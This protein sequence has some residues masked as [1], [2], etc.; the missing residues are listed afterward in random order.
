MRGGLPSSTA[1]GRSIGLSPS[2]LVLD[3]QAAVVGGA[4]RRR[5]TGSARAPH[6]AANVV[7]PVGRDRQHVALLRLV[8][9]QLERRQ[10]GL[11]A[12]DGA[13]LDDAR[14][15]RCRGP[16]RAARSRGRP[17]RRRGSRRSGC[18]RRAPSSGRSPPGSGAASRRCRAARTRS[19]DPRATRPTPATTPR[20]R[21]GRSAS[22]GRR[23]RRWPRPAGCRAFWTCSARGRCRCRPRA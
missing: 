13:Q 6:S 20:R 11:V 10:P 8:A 1:S 23:A 22:P 4:G 17:R 15:A 12:G 14:R 9:P 19:R 21:R 7:Q 3:Q 16:A 5:R 2:R 18:R